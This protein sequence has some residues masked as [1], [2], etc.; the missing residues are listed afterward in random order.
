M[1]VLSW[2]FRSKIGRFLLHLFLTPIALLSVMFI[3]RLVSGRAINWEFFWL[4]T[5]IAAPPIALIN[6]V[7]PR[8]SWRQL[9]GPRSS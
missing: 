1:R 9:F 3:N 4:F 7:F 6:A 8:L 5:G 2:I